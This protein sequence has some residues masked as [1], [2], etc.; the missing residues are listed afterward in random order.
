M[1]PEKKRGR[2]DEHKRQEVAAGHN[3]EVLG[4]LAVPLEHDQPL[5]EP[6]PEVVNVFGLRQNLQQLK[7]EFALLL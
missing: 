4:Q 3:S 5:D 1:P 6:R 7:N 2:N